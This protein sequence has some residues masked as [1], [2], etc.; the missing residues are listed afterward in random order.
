MKLLFLEFLGDIE[1]FYRKLITNT[2]YQ[3]LDSQN[4]L[5]LPILQYLP[6]LQDLHT[7]V[8]L[9]ELYHHSLT[10]WSG[11]SHISSENGISLT[12]DLIT[13]SGKV[14]HQIMCCLKIAI[15][16]KQ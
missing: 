12:M 16:I 9:L 11:R 4:W 7:G 8:Q 15:I 14:N 10:F 3:I 13:I 2:K 5:F 6:I 1:G